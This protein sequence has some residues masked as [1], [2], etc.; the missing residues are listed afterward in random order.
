MCVRCFFFF[1]S[2]RR[3]TRLTC[4]WSSD[5]YSSDLRL[6]L[7]RISECAAVYAV[8]SLPL[9][10]ALKRGALVTA[11]NWPVVIV[12]FIV[13]SIARVALAVPIVGGGCRVAV[14][15]NADGSSILAGGLPSA[16]RIV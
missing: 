16:A 3:H 11:A 13:V 12:Q 7:R 1:S 15:S 14:L 8:V 10:A 4:D 9:R 6:V 5:V 2:R